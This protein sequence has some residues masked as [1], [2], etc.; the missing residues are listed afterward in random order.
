MSMHRERRTTALLVFSFS[1]SGSGGADFDEGVN[2]RNFEI[3]MYPAEPP[4]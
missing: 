3:F 1:K 2:I 4:P